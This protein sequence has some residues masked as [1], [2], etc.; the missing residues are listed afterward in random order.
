MFKKSNFGELS[1]EKI[2]AHR[3]SRRTS[4][5]TIAQHFNIK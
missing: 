2:L 1:L 3:T 4:P 5:H